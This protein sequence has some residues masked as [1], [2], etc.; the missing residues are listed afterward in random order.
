M[1]AERHHKILEYLQTNH[2]ADVEELSNLCKVSPATIRRDLNYLHKQGEIDRVRGGGILKESQAEPLVLPR[3]NLHYEAKRRIGKAAADLVKDGETIIISTGTTTEAMIPFLTEKSGLTVITNALNV[4][5]RLTPYENIATIVLGGL[6][7]HRELDLLGHI[8][9]NSLSDL[10][11]TKLF[12]GVR[13]IHYKQGLTATDIMHVRTDEKMITKVQELIIV[14]DHSKFNRMG[15]VQLGPVT[16]ASTII[17]D[18]EAPMEE[19]ERIRQLGVR[20]ILV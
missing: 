12:R 11:A 17:T 7:R 18:N 20:V 3:A 9:D 15:S 19:V 13:G 2:A 6:L 5:Y 1:R 4:A 16:V 14:A 8:T 10:V